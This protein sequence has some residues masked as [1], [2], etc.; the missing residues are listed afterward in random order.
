MKRGHANKDHSKAEIAS[1][2]D[3]YKPTP[4]EVEALKDF[5]HA[6]AKRAPR[7]KFEKVGSNTVRVR[8]HNQ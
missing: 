8:T 3:K 5:A 1:D 7:L 4:F 6:T 2:G